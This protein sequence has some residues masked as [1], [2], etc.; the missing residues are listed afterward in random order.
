[1][2]RILSLFLA[3]LTLLS[4]CA[5]SSGI[6]APTET[7]PEETSS[8][9]AEERIYT[10]EE[11]KI[12]DER[13]E[14]AASF[15]HKMATVLWRSAEE[16]TY[17]IQSGVTPDQVENTSGLPQKLT[18]QK[19]RLYQGLP[20]TYASNGTGSFS[21]AFTEPDQSGIP[22]VSGLTWQMLSGGGKT[23]RFGNDCATAVMQ[24]W[25]Q[26]SNSFSITSTAYMTENYGFLPVGSYY[27]S[28]SKLS[29]TKN[30]CRING[31]QTLFASYAKL[32][33]ADAVVERN[34]GSGHA[35]LVTSV[36][37]VPSGDSFHPEKSY[38][39]VTH[40][41]RNY[42][43]KD[44]KYYDEK[45][46]EDVY[47]WYGIDDK[48]T[49][50]QLFEYGYLPVTCKE[51]IDPAPLPQLEISSSVTELTAENVFTGE[52]KSNQMIE[53]LSAEIKNDSGAVVQKA[54]VAATRKTKTEFPCEALLDETYALGK[55][56]LVALT[57]GSYTITITANLVNGEKAPVR[58]LSF[59]K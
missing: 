15:M 22:S 49:F 52:I 47:T 24:S 14:L 34:D 44:A 41:T 38:I 29:N 21:Q 8:T 12:L 2:K 37:A 53:F 9:K 56:D 46:G 55:I 58:E 40:Q 48:Y 54:L 17:T 6:Q 18:L 19:G 59:T 5:C 26:V 20:Y 51:L 28:K 4:L 13:R 32:L 27:V 11:R 10:P 39:T 35:M 30:D 57:Q 42:Y 7:A 1:M 50:R 23:A 33:K 31:E 36:H 45:L 43:A 16:I 3:L 25:G